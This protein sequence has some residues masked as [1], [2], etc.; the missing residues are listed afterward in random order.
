M[1]RRK[2]P[3]RA[4]MGTTK[5]LSPSELLRDGWELFEKRRR[6]VYCRQMVDTHLWVSG[7][8]RSGWIYQVRDKATAKILHSG[9]SLRLADAMKTAEELSEPN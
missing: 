4:N 7:G 6:A 2:S 9:R 1:R 5:K 3:L 8:P